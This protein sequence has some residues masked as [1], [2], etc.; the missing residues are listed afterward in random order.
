MFTTLHYIQNRHIRLQFSSVT[1]LTLLWIL[2]IWNVFE[3]YFHTL[4]AHYVNGGWYCP[5]KN[6]MDAGLIMAVCDR[7]WMTQICLAADNS[8]L[9]GQD[10][11]WA[12]HGRPRTAVIGQHP[13]YTQRDSTNPV[14]HVMSVGNTLAAALLVGKLAKVLGKNTKVRN[15]SCTLWFMY[16][17]KQKQEKKT[18]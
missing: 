18:I 7:P 2:L 13:C 3:V 14:S 11:I 8:N 9:S 6:S 17:G 10:M 12:N 16:N 15:S 4:Q 5:W 1:H